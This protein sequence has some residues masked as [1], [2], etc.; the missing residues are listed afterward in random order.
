MPSA[1]L[2][3]G[4]HSLFAWHFDG[5]RLEGM[6]T[7]DFESMLKSARKHA[8][9]MQKPIVHEESPH[10][11]PLLHSLTDDGCLRF[12]LNF[13][14]EDEEKELMIHA[15]QGEEFVS[16]GENLRSVSV[17]GGVP[18]PSGA[19]IEPL[20][21]W[22][23]ALNQRVEA[24]TKLSSNQLLVNLYQ[25]GQGIA[26]HEDGPLYDSLVAIVSLNGTALIEFQGKG[27]GQDFSVFLPPRSL[28]VFSD[29]F[30]SSFHHSI[31]PST[32]FLI[33]SSCLNAELCGLKL[34]K[35]IERGARERISFTFRRVNFIARVIDEFGAPDTE[36]QEEISR[37]KAWWLK[38]IAE[39]SQI[40]IST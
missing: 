29:I 25:S 14:S 10:A 40:D 6:A 3:P 5:K 36:T 28:L 38:S 24:T 37:R 8:K 18:H 2:V 34:G 12:C 32:S 7:I 22:I 9:A 16:L 13:I 26:S 15:Q 33:T 39:K 4:L 35:E 11:P 30:Y 20:P 27:Q 1:W 19:I 21:C 31:S 17:L 23:S